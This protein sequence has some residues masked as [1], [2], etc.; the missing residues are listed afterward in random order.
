MLALK[1]VRV[2]DFLGVALRGLAFEA[3]F[4]PA[5]TLALDGER[6]GPGFHECE[7]GPHRW[8]GARARIDVA[9]LCEHGGFLRL[10][11]APPA[12]R[13]AA[14]DDESLVSAA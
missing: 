6:L 13:W 9:G 7:P 1:N 4:G 2:S 3:G 10:D 12:P 11:L 8:T 5:Q 14:P